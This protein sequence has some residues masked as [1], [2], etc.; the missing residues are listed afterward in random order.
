[1]VLEQVEYT[2]PVLFTNEE[3]WHSNLP[4]KNNT[5]EN[6]M[7]DVILGIRKSMSFI[8]NH[9]YNWSSAI[10]IKIPFYIAEDK[11][12]V[13]NRLQNL[14]HQCEIPSIGVLSSLYDGQNN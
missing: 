14:K 2:K 5:L 4:Y 9:R 12:K 1:M 11:N 8:I 7:E 13:E 3:A 10:R 6:L